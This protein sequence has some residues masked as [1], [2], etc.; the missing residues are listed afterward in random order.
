MI[1]SNA[2]TSYREPASES[3]G[4][5]GQAWLVVGVHVVVGDVQRNAPPSTN[6]MSR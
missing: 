4:K 6:S 5:Y 1:S 2:V 3:D